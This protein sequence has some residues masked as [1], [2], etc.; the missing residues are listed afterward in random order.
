MRSGS[1]AVNT[2]NPLQIE[3]LTLRFGGRLEIALPISVVDAFSWEGGTVAGQGTIT[4]TGG[5]TIDGSGSGKLDG[6]RV[7]VP[8][9]ATATH[10]A[11]SSAFRGAS[12]GVIEIES[13]AVFDFQDGGG[14]RDVS[15]GT[16]PPRLV[17]RGTLKNSG[18]GNSKVSWAV[19]N[20]GTFT[21]TDGTHRFAGQ[22]IDQGGTYRAAGAT[23]V[24]DPTQKTTFGSGSVLRAD[25]SGTI[26]VTNQEVT[27]EGTYDV[28]GTTIVRSRRLTSTR[29]PAVTIAPSA[30]LQDLG[31]TG[32][33]VDR[34]SLAVKTGDPLTVDSLE[35]N[36]GQL[37]NKEAITARQTLTLKRGRLVSEGPLTTRQAFTWEDGTI[38]GTGTIR[39]EGGL[40]VSGGTLDGR[41]LVVPSGETAVHPSGG[42]S[43]EGTGGAVIEVE[44]GAVYDFRGSGGLYYSAGSSATPPRLVN[45]GTLKKTAGDIPSTIRWK[46]ENHGAVEAT[47]NVFQ[48]LK[49]LISDGTILTE[50]Q[51]RLVYESSR[52]L[53]NRGTIRVKSLFRSEPP[54]QNKGGTVAVFD[55][56]TLI[57]GQLNDT[58]TNPDTVLVLSEGG[59]LRGG[60]TVTG[61]VVNAGGTVRP[62]TDGGPGELQVQ[63]DYGQKPG[64]TLD[65]E[66]GGTAP[67][68]EYD[69]LEMENLNLG[70]TL[71]LALIS[72]FTPDSTDLLTPIRWSGSRTGGPDTIK[73]QDAGDVFLSIKFT[74]GALQVSNGTAP[75]SPDLPAP[76]L[77]MSSPPFVRTGNKVWAT[78]R[79]RNRSSNRIIVPVGELGKSVVVDGS[80][81]DC[82]TTSAYKNL[83]CR[84]A[85][86]G[87]S[88]PKPPEGKS[89]P[90]LPREPLFSSSGS[91]TDGNETSKV[92]LPMLSK[93]TTRMAF[94]NGTGKVSKM[95]FGGSCKG[96]VDNVRVKGSL[97]DRVAS[98]IS[99]Q[100]CAYGIGKKIVEDVAGAYV[101]GFACIKQ[102]FNFGWSIG[103]GIRTGRFD[104]W[105]F[106]LA[107]SIGALR[108][109]GD[110]VKAD[111]AIQLANKTKDL[112][113]K[114]KQIKK[115]VEACAPDP[116]SV[117]QDRSNTTCVGAI[118]P[119]DK[120]G[121]T[122]T[123]TE[124]YISARDSLPYTV[125]FEN[126]SSAT[127]PAQQVV[128]DDTLDA[129]RFDL[130]TFSFGTVALGDTSIAVPEDTLAFSKEVDL[131]PDRDVIVR[132]EGSVDEMTG[133]L[134]WTFTS[135]DPDT[136][137]PVTDPLAGFLPPNEDPP[138]GQ[139][140]VSYFADLESD[141]PSGAQFGRAAQIVFDNNDPIGT[142]VWSNTLDIEPPRSRVD[143]LDP[144]QNNVEFEVSWTGLDGE[145][146]VQRYSVYVKEGDGSFTEWIADT[147]TTSATFKG[148]RGTRYAFYSVAT[149]SVGLTEPTPSLADASTKVAADAIPVE[150][151]RMEATLSEEGAVT[152]T[153]KTASETNNVG[154][155]VQRRSGPDG[156]FRRI[157]FV[158][159]AGTTSEPQT[160]RFTDEQLPYAADTLRYRLRQVDTD[161]TGHLTDPVAVG[162]GGPDRLELRETFPNPARTQ[163]TVR[164]SIPE[165]G[166][167]RSGVTVTLYD[168][169]GR[170]VRT[171]RPDGKAGRHEIQLSVQDLASGVYVL[172]LQTGNTKRT[173]RLTVVR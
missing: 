76:E 31:T 45:R 33:T 160:Y 106:V 10:V 129:D 130:S 167:R 132:I 22:I 55:A 23:L 105:G 121:P 166:G 56:G 12:G 98:D 128:I 151:T 60:G 43:L 127:A 140:S 40:T 152:M 90:F 47:H 68:S 35:L 46:V 72:G 93:T 79:I 133:V 143:S 91:T 95:V 71:R 15:G 103:Q 28:A 44:S 149:D 82:P 7:V 25:S 17:N 11:G 52:D 67:G 146:G 64:G 135:L 157:G 124:R 159:G 144:T 116:A 111:L 153:W 156:T 137:E 163:V 134:E 41:R 48:F 37:S 117:A 88:L 87:V 84:F 147:T 164:Y 155:E 20:H 141:V 8:S 89:Y 101:P 115:M 77:R 66:L 142:G 110:V 162:R 97:A 150:L 16:S 1:L 158:E 36:G 2:T 92:G 6:G 75:E 49:P 70:G 138:E 14:L 85:R 102:S 27:F 57:Q 65:L 50:D 161:G 34:G 53:V 81:S 83:K 109:A 78:A 9:G 74:S 168:L 3:T 24:F 21:L 120:R 51:A 119:N 145:S 131:R 136:M 58:P 118:D 125:F 104:M 123:C 73:G 61:N 172:R 170:R 165:R 126:K 154:F 13:G 171:V 113:D 4:A 100:K 39:A 62:G 29:R 94:L 38:A 69:R 99:L 30:D 96:G 26:R 112:A 59:V 107:T 32:L 63:G 114:Q 173:R 139:G 108:C 42:N 86:F 54:V 19:E 122:G 5:L 80:I 148:T 18:V 169:L